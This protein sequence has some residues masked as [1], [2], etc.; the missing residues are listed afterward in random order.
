MTKTT[1]LDIGAYNNRLCVKEEDGRY[2]WSISTMNDYSG[3]MGMGEEWDTDWS[4]IS[5][6]LYVQ[7]IKQQAYTDSIEVFKDNLDDMSMED[8]LK[9]INA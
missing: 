9:V 7:I 4:E 2:Y 5:N 8:K 3:S 1:I 6:E